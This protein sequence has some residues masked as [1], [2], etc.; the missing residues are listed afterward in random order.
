[1][2]IDVAF[3]Q[4]Y[5]LIF[6]VMKDA[7]PTITFK[8]KSYPCWYDYELSISLKHN[9]NAR[10]RFFKSGYDKDSDEYHEYANLNAKSKKLAKAC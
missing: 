4:F 1:M 7:I 10:R 3:S 6:A 5:D 8:R 2:E 9:L